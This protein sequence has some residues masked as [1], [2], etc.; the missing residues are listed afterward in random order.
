MYGPDPDANPRLAT[1][2]AAA[3]KQGVPKT[4]IDN[5]IARGQ[6]VS[7]KGAA[8]ETLT[9]EAIIP[10][11]VATIIECQTDSKARTLADIRMVIKDFGGAVTPT[12]HF[13]ERRGKLVFEK[14]NGLSESEIFDKAVEAEATDVRVEEGG[15]VVVYTEPNRTKATAQRLE[16]G[17]RLK[18]Q[19]SDLVW[20]AKQET[21]VEVESAD[22]LE[23]FL[24]RV[25]EDASVQG[26]YTNT[27][28]S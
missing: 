15:E 21:K 16:G 23:A 22:E 26:V 7:P 25:Q 1:L 2:V 27:N 24:E 20:D 13:F 28:Q 17:L 9:V 8:L 10:P 6:G 3:K 5:A 4:T 14:V 18:V 11:S 12:T 19:S